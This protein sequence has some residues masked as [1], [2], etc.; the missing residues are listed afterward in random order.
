MDIWLVEWLLLL[1]GRKCLKRAL[2]QQHI[3]IH[4]WNL[5]CP[6]IWSDIENLHPCL[7]K[8]YSVGSPFLLPLLLLF[9]FNLHEPHTLHQMGWL[10]SLFSPLKKLWF[11]LNSTQ[12]KSMFHNTLNFSLFSF[13]SCLCSQFLSFP[14]TQ[15]WFFIFFKYFLN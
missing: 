13:L 14:S 4:E 9:P 10:Q 12:K 7:S 8:A 15:K 2:Y 3:L 11:K 5:I 6:K 1:Q